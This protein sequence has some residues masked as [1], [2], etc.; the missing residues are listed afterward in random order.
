MG[1]ERL[2]ILCGIEGDDLVVAGEQSRAI[3]SDLGGHVPKLED[4]PWP[5]FPADPADLRALVLVAVTPV[6]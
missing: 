3:Q 6:T 5:A 4:Q 1:F 2:G